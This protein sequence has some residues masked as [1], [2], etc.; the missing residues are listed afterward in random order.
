[1]E[2]IPLFGTSTKGKST[3][4][5]AQ[6][7]INV[8]AER[9]Q[10][11]DVDKAEFNLLAR[12]GLTLYS[13]VTE[14][15]LA[16]LVRGFSEQ[17]SV[18]LSPGIFADQFFFV[19]GKSLYTG[20]VG[21]A[22]VQVLAGV[23]ASTTGPVAMATNPTQLLV[24]DGVG[25]NIFLLQT[26]YT[27]TGLGATSFPPTSNAVAFIA[28]R[29][30]AV[31]PTN[32]G[33]FYWS[34]VNNGTLWAALDFATAESA[35]DPLVSIKENAGELILLGRDT[36]EFW[37]PSGDTAVFRR[38]Q[39]AGLD[40]GCLSRLSVAKAKGGVVFLGRQRTGADAQVIFLLNHNA[41]ELSDPDVTFDINNEPSLT[42][43]VGFSFVS[44]G[45]TFYQLNLTSTSWVYDFSSKLWS[46]FKSGTAPETRHLAQFATV[47]GNK[48]FVSD[49]AAN[50]IYT[51]DLASFTDNGALFGCEIISKH[52]IA[53]YERFGISELYIDVETGVGLQSGQGSDPKIMGQWS[54]DG[55]RTFGNESWQSAG[56]VGAYR[57]RAT[58]RNLG[59]AVDWVFRFRITDPVK[60]VFTNAAMGI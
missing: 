34:S 29:F 45:H 32:P 55:G 39:G 59:E 47:S 16:V 21:A 43:A 27:Q 22:V 17:S 53:G 28:G 33:R 11:A 56:A 13:A 40:Y 24:A 5:S 9:Y 51:L 48:V 30:V 14:T 50:N 25:G 18:A 8:T 58:W 37:S 31:D 38:L 23:L 12:A 57:T 35:P 3:T 46:E 15:A 42:D 26:P 19:A 41:I 44:G 49:Y 4:I 60:R 7:R 36:T 54:K 1:M 10:G 20:G 52:A 2:L 6:R